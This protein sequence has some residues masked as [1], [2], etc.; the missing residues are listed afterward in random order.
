MAAN[1]DELAREHLVAAGIWS[2]SGARDFSPQVAVA[3]D[4]AETAAFLVRWIECRSSSPVHRSAT[5]WAG[6]SR[7]RL[8]RAAGFV[9]SLTLVN[10]DGNPRSR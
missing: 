6:T 3:A 9:R 1:F 2:D 10:S 5:R 8:P 7:S 4:F